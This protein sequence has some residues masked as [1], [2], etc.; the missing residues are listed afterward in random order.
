MNKLQRIPLLTTHHLS[1]LRGFSIV[2]MLISTALLAVVMIVAT[3]SL[4]A[5]LKN[6]RK[7]DSISKV[8]E[9]V[10]YAVSTMERLLRNAQSVTCTTPKKLDYVDEYDNTTYFNCITSGGYSFIA[11]GS[12][13]TKLTSSNV[14][15][16]CTA[17][18]NCPV[19]ASGVPATVEITLK[20]TEHPSLGSEGSTITSKTRIQLRNYTEF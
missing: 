11:S 15:I 12:A 10:D 3:Q 19:S 14:N 8:R 2:E 4:A 16:D 18:F 5:S 7:S 13:T 17:V 1:R 6:S 20:G 9:N